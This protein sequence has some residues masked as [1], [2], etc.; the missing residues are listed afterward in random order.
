M[1]VTIVQQNILWE[2]K[3]ENLNHL[4]SLLSSLKPGETD[5]IIL[6][7]MFTTGFSMNARDHAVDMQSTEVS[8]MTE[9]AKILYTGI[10]G[11]MIV[12]ENNR[13]YNRL[14]FATRD[15]IQGF[16]DKRHLF[17]MS[18]E[19]E[20]YSP[21]HTVYEPSWKNWKI[22]PLICYDLRFPVWSRN[23]SN[24]HLLIYVANWPASRSDIW[25][26][27]LKARAIENQAYV[28][29]VNRTGTDGN[30]VSYSGN[31]VVF[32]PK[33]EVLNHNN[34]NNEFIETIEL[35]MSDLLS[36]KEKF[37]AWMDSDIFSIE[38]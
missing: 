18:N 25:T 11:S 30:K 8:W 13:C 12:S 24:Y 19:N 38:I 2:N 34:S 35:S 15:G 36:F 37:P 33:G 17:R 4:D 1:K 29:G 3:S 32:S 9:K 16:Y 31:S 6:P 14:I 21:G 28:V 22:R 5:L 10:M 7:E 27:L 26:S 23:T 20:N